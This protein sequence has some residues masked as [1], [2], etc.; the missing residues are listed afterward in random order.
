MARTV[1]VLR[2]AAEI[3]AVVDL[4]TAGEVKARA[5]E[6]YIDMQTKMLT[7]VNFM[8]ALQFLQADRNRRIQLAGLFGF[9]GISRGT[10][11]G[12]KASHGRMTRAS[13]AVKISKCV[14]AES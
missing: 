12:G 5:V 6:E 3:L 4:M 10:T 14:S 11:Q 7:H 8:V 9:Y 1:E 13:R 2:K